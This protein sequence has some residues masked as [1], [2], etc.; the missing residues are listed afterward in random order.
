MMSFVRT[1]FLRLYAIERRKGT[2]D[3]RASYKEA[4]F[5]TRLLVFVPTVSAMSVVLVSLGQL[6]PWASPILAD[7]YRPFTT[8]AAVIWG[9]LVSFVLV[10]RAIGT[11][12]NIPAM[13]DQH[14]S[15]RDRLMSHVSFWCTAVVSLSFAFFFGAALHAVR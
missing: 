4:V 10:K 8:A 14:S 15:D 1:Y 3:E 6:W 7:E 5:Q 12:D 2:K 13:A 9:L 11:I